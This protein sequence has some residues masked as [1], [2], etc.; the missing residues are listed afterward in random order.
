MRSLPNCKI[1]FAAADEMYR[2]TQQMSLQGDDD[3]VPAETIIGAYLGWAL[4]EIERPQ[5]II[6][7]PLEEEDWKADF[8]MLDRGTWSCT[9]DIG[10]AKKWHS[11]YR[12]AQNSNLLRKQEIEW[13][14][15]DA[16]QYERVI[17]ARLEVIDQQAARI[18]EL[19]SLRQQ[20]LNIIGRSQKTS[21]DGL[22]LYLND[23][24]DYNWRITKRIGELEAAL[25]DERARHNANEEGF[26]WPYLARKEP[27][28][29]E[30][31][32]FIARQELREEGK[33]GTSDQFPDTTK[34]IWQITEGRKAAIAAMSSLRTDIDCPE[35]GAWLHFSDI[36]QHGSVLQSMLKEAE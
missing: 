10:I 32:R 26:S 4:D 34:L 35:C 18:K 5:R 1:D 21:D 25:V 23:E 36:A 13:L 12:K 22:L 20:I 11:A 2:A 30:E 31:Y 8:E 9:V 29:Q 24:V 7:S 16:E 6:D 15:V 3:G 28:L 27:D 17:E 19:E 33:I 14:R